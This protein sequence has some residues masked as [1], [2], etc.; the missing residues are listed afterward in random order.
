[1]QDSQD[2]SNLSAEVEKLRLEN[3]K[4]QKIVADMTSRFA[5]LET[6]LSALEKGGHGDAPAPVAAK[7][8]VKQYKVYTVGH[9]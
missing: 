1:M 2:S 6:R 5:A 7:P 8:Q 9:F 4:L 3:D